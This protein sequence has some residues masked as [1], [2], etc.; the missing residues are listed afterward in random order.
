M[1]SPPVTFASLAK[2]GLLLQQGMTERTLGYSQSFLMT[3]LIA[4]AT[5]VAIATT[6]VHGMNIIG[7]LVVCLIYLAL[8]R[9]EGEPAPVKTLEN[10][11]LV[12]E[13]LVCK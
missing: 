3:P 11:H 1:M 4:T 6:A 12:T 5:A 2:C 7:S 13:M 9:P 8:V 10:R